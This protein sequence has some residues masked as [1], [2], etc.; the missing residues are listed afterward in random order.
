MGVIVK[1]KI[2]GSNEWWVFLNHKGM[3]RSKK[4][5]PKKTAEKVAEIM[6][7][8]LTLGHSLVGREEKPPAPTLKQYYEGFK[9]VWAT[10]VKENSFR[11]YEIGFR[12]HILPVLGNYRMDEI[13]REKMERFVTGLVKNGLAKATIRLIL[14]PLNLLYRR[15]IKHKIISENPTSEMSEFYRQAPVLHE[16]IE[17]LT[18]EECI[19][20]L[21]TALGKYPEDYPVLLSALHTGMRA[22]ELAGLQWPDIDWNGSF[23]SV[24]R[25]FAHGVLS[26]LKTKYARR[27]VDCSDELLEVLGKLRKQ[28][29][30]EWMKR[31]EPNCPDWVFCSSLGNP[32]CWNNDKRNAL[33]RTLKKAGL[34]SIR[35]HDLRHTYASLLLAQGE[36]VTYVSNQL[37]H[38]NPQ[39]TLKVYAHWVPNKSQRQAVN[40]LP[41]LKQQVRDLQNTPE[42]EVMSIDKKKLV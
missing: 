20:V 40:R 29:L 11:L 9:D 34:R 35:F 28:R 1:E 3:R 6:R 42:T 4:C 16:E 33:K 37:G 14:A 24:K 7:A 19:L 31:G 26:S 12:V 25:Q 36:P 32:D 23:I 18:Q 15:A 17:P 39:I 22:G 13:D 5:G 2:K 21:K 27:K 38:S 30:E 41:S 10:T 8:N